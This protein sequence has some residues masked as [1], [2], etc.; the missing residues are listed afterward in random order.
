MP[1]A[2]IELE[3]YT[4]NWV[5]KFKSE[6]LFLENTIGNWIHGGIEHVGSTS[7]PDMMAKPVIDIMVGVES[8]DIA[9]PAIGVLS[10]NGYAYSPYKGDV[11]HWF[12]KPSDAFRTHHLHLIPYQSPLWNE[13]LLFRD[14]LRRNRAVA[15]EYAQLKAE[16][17]ND[18]KEDREAYTQKKWPF[19]K[20]VLDQYKDI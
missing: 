3:N 8:L 11:M 6:R 2:K 20:S 14:I 18:Y 16:L 19:I 1:R 7:V 5:S 4:P 10:N 9:R 12:C 15:D 17:A 13:R